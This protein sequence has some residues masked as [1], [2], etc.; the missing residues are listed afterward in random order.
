MLVLL[1]KYIPIPIGKW[2]TTHL[3]IELIFRYY[4]VVTEVKVKL[5]GDTYL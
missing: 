2:S 3:V 4:S 5:A 1:F